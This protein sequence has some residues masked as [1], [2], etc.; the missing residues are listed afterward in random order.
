MKDAA[1][2]LSI[3]PQFI[4]FFYFVQN[5]EMIL[6]P[7][8]N[9]GRNWFIREGFHFKLNR[10]GFSFSRKRLFTQLPERALFH[11]SRRR[12]PAGHQ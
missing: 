1:L 8:Q 3:T 6:I 7:V 10:K 2:I 11:L 12:E 4:R 9:A 5:D